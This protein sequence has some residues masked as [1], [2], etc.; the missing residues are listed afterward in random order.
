[1]MYHSSLTKGRKISYYN[2]I[3]IHSIHKV[4]LYSLKKGKN[5]IILYNFDTNKIIINELRL[6][7][8]IRNHYIT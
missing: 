5:N 3:I 1:M 4:S 8:Y 6:L 2:K 7:L